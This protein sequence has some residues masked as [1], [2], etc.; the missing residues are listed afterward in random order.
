MEVK[1]VKIMN[2]NLSCQPIKAD[3]NYS[4][5][6]FKRVIP[7]K[8]VSVKSDSF[9]KTPDGQM[10]LNLEE[11]QRST[12]KDDKTAALK[13]LIKILTRADEPEGKANPKNR[14]IRKK[15]AAV[16]KDYKPPC[17]KVDRKEDITVTPCYPLDTDRI[18][19]FTGYDAYKYH[20]KGKEIGIARHDAKHHDAD[21]AIINKRK[22]AYGRVTD[23]F[24]CDPVRRLRYKDKNEL[25]AMVI[26]VDELSKKPVIKDISFEPYQNIAKPATK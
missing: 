13:A 20:E 6:S 4:N 3:G 15:F 10:L 24:S 8:A 22:K 2:T 18:Y 16:V 17:G 11:P 25:L 7:I 12:E 26:H 1:G 21:T 23:E 14:E 5:V 9:E 19:L